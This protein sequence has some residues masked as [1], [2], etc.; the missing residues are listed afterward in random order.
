MLMLPVAKASEARREIAMNA[1][2]TVGRVSG[3][4]PSISSA[5]RRE[6]LGRRRCLARGWSS[7]PERSSLG[8]RQLV[9]YQ[10]NHDLREVVRELVEATVPASSEAEPPR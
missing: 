10:A 4:M 7:S 3:A 9:V 6:S 8:A 2:V 5:R 1:S